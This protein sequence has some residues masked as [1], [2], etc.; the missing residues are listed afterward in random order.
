MKRIYLTRGKYAV[1][2]N[3]DYAKLSKINWYFDHGYARNKGKNDSVYMHRYIMGNKLRVNIDHINGNKL[4]NR[5]SNLRFCSQA[6]NSK[7]S[8][9]HKDSKYS[10]YKGVSYNKSLGYWTATICDNGKIVTKYTN[11]ENK[12]ARIYNQLALI[13]H[14]DFAKLNTI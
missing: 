7:N 10:K 4:D 5:K 9:S 6:Q 11:S 2:D 1:V 12:A 3:D 8:V 14:G 13:Y